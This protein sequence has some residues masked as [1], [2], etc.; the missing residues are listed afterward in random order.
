[1]QSTFTHHQLMPGSLDL[2]LENPAIWRGDQYAKV[3]VESVATGFPELDAQLPGGGWP[4]A[5]LTELLVNRPPGV[6]ELRLLM[7][8]LGAARASRKMAG[9]G[10]ASASAVCTRFPIRRRRFGARGRGQ[11]TLR[12][13]KP[14]GHRA[15]SALRQLRSGVELGRFGFTVDAAPPA[16]CGGRRQRH[17]RG[18]RLHASC[19]ATLPAPLRIQVSAHRTGIELQILKRRGGG[20][21]PPVSLRMNPEKPEKIEPIDSNDI[22][23]TRQI[24]RAET[25]HSSEASRYTEDMSDDMEVEMSDM[26]A[27]LESK[28]RAL[29]PEERAELIRLLIA[30]L[31]GPSDANIEKAWLQEAQKRYRE[32]TEGKVKQFQASK[33]LRICVR[34]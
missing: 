11:N 26:V 22:C 2:I 6:G 10:R 28:I 17:R 29:S 32:I 4:R 12:R 7:A 9:A 8:G 23:G 25:A 1:M 19:R 34:V 5:A 18:V 24:R 3:A 13:R 30:D 20:W 15:L 27:E 31:D 33:C 16:A 21:A 14:V